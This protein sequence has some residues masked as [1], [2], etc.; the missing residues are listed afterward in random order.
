MHPIAWM[1]IYSTVLSN[2]L[3]IFRKLTSQFLS[4]VWGNWINRRIYP[5][6]FILLWPILQ[7]SASY[8]RQCILGFAGWLNG[9]LTSIGAISLSPEN[10]CRFCGVLLFHRLLTSV[11]K[12]DITKPN[13]F[14]AYWTT[15]SS[16]WGTSSCKCIMYLESK[17]HHVGY[18]KPVTDNTGNSESIASADLCCC[19]IIALY[20]SQ[21]YHNL[22]K[23]RIDR[24]EKMS[25]YLYCSHFKLT[26]FGKILL[27]LE[28][29][30]Q[31]PG[32]FFFFL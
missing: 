7:R 9:M 5:L 11:L 31:D 32:P 2:M 16:S 30:N 28:K 12:F 13:F 17:P 4:M 21:V 29:L 15:T 3:A 10:N 1:A 24:G 6:L 23:L 25:L 19:E 22:V 14:H 27:F 18:V 26:L 20:W 8:C